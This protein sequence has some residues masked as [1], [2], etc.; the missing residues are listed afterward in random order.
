MCNMAFI[1]TF[2][3]SKPDVFL[4][5]ASTTPMLKK[6]ISA[7]RRCDKK[8]FANPSAIY[9]K[10]MESKKTVE[11]S[12]TSVARVLGCRSEEVIFTA[13][14]TESDNL[15]ILGICEANKKKFVPHIITSAIEHPAVR[16][17]CV[18][19]E[20]RGYKVTYIPVSPLGKVDSKKI[21]EEITENTVLVSIMLA[22]NEIGTIEPIADISRMIKEIREKN[23]TPF[24]YLHTDACQAANYIS[25]NINSLGVDMLSLDGSKIYGPKGVG[26]LFIKR[27]INISP[28]IFG[29]G[30]EKGLRSGTEN[31]SG[32][33][34]FSLALKIAQKDRERESMRLLKLR[35]YFI[36]KLLSISPRISVNGD[37][38]NRLPNNVN[39]CVKDLDAE[40]V[41]IKM[42]NFGIS[43]SAGSSCGALTDTL[44]SDVISALG[45]KDCRTSSIRFSMGRQTVKKDIDSAVWAFEKILE[46]KS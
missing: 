24:P 17:A 16:E 1:K 34:G 41:V 5:F 30:Q 39:V 18:E 15:A 4:D 11:L 29:G 8:I 35:E 40:F 13:S 26:M 7:M 22:N 38:K 43:C 23:K 12:R 28:I 19:A 10:G 46:A 14:G 9:K 25:M 31:I 21:V 3:R 42:D 6:V 20:K 27:G 37:L 32:I 33:V 36:K 44:S 45:N 2:L